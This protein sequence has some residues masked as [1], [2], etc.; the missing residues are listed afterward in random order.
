MKKKVV[1]I[2]FVIIAL[3]KPCSLA[4][5]GRTDGYGGHYNR[6]TG[7]YH[8]HTGAYSGEYT[9]PVE[10][11][12]IRID[13]NKYASQSNSE[14][15]LKVNMNDTRDF[16]AITEENDRLKTEVETKSGAELAVDPFHA[17]S[18]ATGALDELRRRSWREARSRPAPKRRRGRPRKGEPAP[19][20]PA[21]R[22][23]GLRFPLL[24]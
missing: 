22:V 2:I 24:K 6:S 16:N 18:W 11:G 19:P 23:K 14:T 8:Y 10:E 13:K 12:G 21:G 7:T 17:V 3:I 9:A 15:K 20:D 4:H 5:S 1:L